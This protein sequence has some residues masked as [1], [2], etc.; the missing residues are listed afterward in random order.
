MSHLKTA[1]DVLPEKIEGLIKD[2]LKDLDD[3]WLKREEKE[4]L[5][6][7]F[8]AKFGVDKGNN[9]CE[10]SMSFMKEKIHDKTKFIFDDKQPSLPFKKKEK[11]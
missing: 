10:V 3:A 7:T 9:V 1:L 8:V 6:V 2:Y 4:S 5:A 11:K